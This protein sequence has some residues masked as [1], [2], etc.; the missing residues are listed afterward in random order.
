MDGQMDGWMDGQLNNWIGEEG[1]E[2]WGRRGLPRRV[3][4][5]LSLWTRHRGGL[6]GPSS[7]LHR[8]P[9]GRA[10]CPAVSRCTGGSTQPAPA[11]PAT[12]SPERP[13]RVWQGPAARGKCS[14]NQKRQFVRLPARLPSPRVCFGEDQGP[15]ATRTGLIN[16]P[17]WAACLL[18][19][20]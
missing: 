13:L 4:L 19:R 5:W 16:L 7:V 2:G 1:G 8:C 11:H 9:S 3:H 17:S 14:G 20:P 18:G 10:S 15:Q 6:P 12:P